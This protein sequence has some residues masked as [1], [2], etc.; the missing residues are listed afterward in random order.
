MVGH[1]TSQGR[2]TSQEMPFSLSLFPSVF[3]PYLSLVFLCFSFSFC[4]L[5]PFFLSLSLCLSLDCLCFLIV[6]V[7]SLISLSLFPSVS[8][9]LSLCFYLSLSLSSLSLTH[10]LSS[11]SAGRNSSQCWHRMPPQNVHRSILGGHN[12]NICLQCGSCTTQSKCSLLMSYSA[13]MSIGHSSRSLSMRHIS[14]VFE[15][16]VSFRGGKTMTCDQ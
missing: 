15:K 4:S 12:A 7:P 5:S 9:F 6:S 1:N 11:S 2:E 13:L 10:C 16:D 8:L 3:L 14:S